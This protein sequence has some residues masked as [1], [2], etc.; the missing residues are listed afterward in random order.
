MTATTRVV[1]HGP[2]SKRVRGGWILELLAVRGLVTAYD[3]GRDQLTGTRAEAFDHAKQIVTAER[4]TGMYHEETIQELF[5]SWRGFIGFWNVFY[6]TAHFIV[7]VI[8][9]VWLYRKAPARYVRWRNTLLCMLVLALIGFWLY[10]LMPPRLMPESYG[11]VDTRLDYY[12]LGETSRS[13]AADNIYAA[14]PSLHIGISSLVAFALWPMVSRP[15][16]KALLVA[17]PVAQLFGTV[18]TANHFVL[19]GV[20]GLL[21][22]A[23]AWL[24]TAIPDRVRDR[25]P[26]PPASGRQ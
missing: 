26:E 12:R 13:T 23:I 17:Y 22:L 24:L 9:L 2:L 7:P 18:V 25:A 20:G 10:P 3:W 16:V 5:L 15:W 6:G 11:F 4:W 21:V 19:D 8:A 1:A 14:M